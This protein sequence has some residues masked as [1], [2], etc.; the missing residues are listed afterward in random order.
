MRET[1][2]KVD[3]KGREMHDEWRDVRER[4]CQATTWKD[5]TVA[6]NEPNQLS[7]IVPHILLYIY[8]L[9]IFVWS[10]MFTF[11]SDI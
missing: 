5:E 1:S 3:E 4:V 9:E 10:G 2:V 6:K 8:K 7:L 11:N